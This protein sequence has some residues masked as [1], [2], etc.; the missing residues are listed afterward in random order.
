MSLE[1]KQIFEV[2]DIDPYKHAKEFIESELIRL[3]SQIGI[4]EQILDLMYDGIDDAQNF[5]SS[6]VDE[7]RNI[8]DLVKQDYSNIFRGLIGIGSR[9]ESILKEVC[10]PF[11]E[12]LSKLKELY[13]QHLELDV[14]LEN[15]D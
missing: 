15:I 2:E 1:Q 12:F 8:K 5:Q 9:Y 6:R 3:E 10:D 13:Q 11:D 7:Y 14:S 4:M